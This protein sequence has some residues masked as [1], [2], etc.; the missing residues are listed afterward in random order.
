MNTPA[1]RVRQGLR[2]A[3]KEGV[4]EV[5]RRRGREDG[6]DALGRGDGG[7]R[8]GRQGAAAPSCGRESRATVAKVLAD[9]VYDSKASFRY[10]HDQ[11][12]SL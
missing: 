7:G 6:Q 5:P 12:W 2:R 11:A 1:G 9:E 3:V 10:L 4:R 8:G